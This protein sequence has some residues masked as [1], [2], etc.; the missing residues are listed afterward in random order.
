MWH[1]DLLSEIIRDPERRSRFLERQKSRRA[2]SLSLGGAL[3]LLGVILMLL[4]DS[5]VNSVISLL[6]VLQIAMA[7]YRDLLVKLVTAVAQTR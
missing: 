1:D 7:M 3:F 5:Q 4:H 6:G 2:I